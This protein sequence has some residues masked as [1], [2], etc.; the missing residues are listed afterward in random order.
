MIKYCIFTILILGYS[1]QREECNTQPCSGAW[2]VWTA[3]EAC[4]VDCGLG[5]KMRSRLCFS[6]RDGVLCK[7][8]NT[9][10]TVCQVTPCED[11]KGTGE[12]FHAQL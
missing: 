6:E 9:D 8:R 7:G 1:T 11:G 5:V 10:M 3:W 4:D 12:R 2:G